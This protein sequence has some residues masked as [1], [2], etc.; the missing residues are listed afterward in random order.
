M[1]RCPYCAEKIKDE[2]IYCKFCHMKIKGIWLRRGFKI[3]IVLA[4]AVFI[5]LHWEMVK[6]TGQKVRFFVQDLDGVWENVKNLIASLN[7]GA[8]KVKGYNSRM[9]AMNKLT[10]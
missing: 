6:E 3:A 4:A 1:K 8:S 7:E 5:A 9:D 10:M 2:A